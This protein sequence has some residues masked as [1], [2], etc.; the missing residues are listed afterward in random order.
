MSEAVG[1]LECPFCDY[2]GSRR[3][4]EAHI[5]GKTDEAHKGKLGRQWRDSIAASVA[6]VGDEGADQ[7]DPSSDTSEEAS[8][9][10]LDQPEGESDLPAGWA[11]VAATVL[12]AVVVLFLVSD[13][14][15]GSTVNDGQSTV[16][17]GQ[18]TEEEDEEQVALLEG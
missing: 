17:G 13:V 15:T 6:E 3:S 11:L 7:E 16:D 4:I 10:D 14:E 8:L 9:P 12:F 5:S 2:R 18:S 1:R